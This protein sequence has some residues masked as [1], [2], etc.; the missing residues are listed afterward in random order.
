M[1]SEIQNKSNTRYIL[2][3]IILME[4]ILGGVTLLLAFLNA[5]VLIFNI[6]PLTLDITRQIQAI[7]Q[8]PLKQVLESGGIISLLIGAIICFVGGL[9]S[10]QSPSQGLS[11][12]TYSGMKAS[13]LNRL[14]Q[15]RILW[16]SKNFSLLALGM[17][18]LVQG[19]I[20]FIISIY[21]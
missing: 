12:M 2:R 13:E 20:F 6:E 14:Q 5:I 18:F 17:S 15:A 3:H 21:C 11:A 1:T 19:V 8:N 7:R 16:I 4:T 9:S 10:T